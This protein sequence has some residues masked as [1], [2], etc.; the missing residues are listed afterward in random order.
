MKKLAFLIIP[1]LA[2]VGGVHAAAA[3]ALPAKDKPQATAAPAALSENKLQPPE[4][5]KIELK[6]KSSFEME[7]NNRNPFWPIGWKPSAKLGDAAVEHAGPDI[8]VS[9]FVVSSI[10][11]ERGT[12]FAIVNGK[13]MQ[14]GQ[15][16]GLQ[17]GSQTYQI[18]LKAIEDGRVVV[19][20]RDQ[21]II[22]PLRRK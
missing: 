16:F 7:G 18:T 15:Q 3:P 9:A 5:P 4:L 11:I 19:A 17:L 13:I 10:T 1:V 6:N 12:K 22:I 2:V 21:E 20:R 14:E 8:P